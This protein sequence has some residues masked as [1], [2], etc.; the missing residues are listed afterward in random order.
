MG[1]DRD[2]SEGRVR[3]LAPSGTVLR[4][5]VDAEADACFREIRIQVT[6]R[7]GVGKT[8]VRSVLSAHHELRTTD[9]AIEETASIDV[10]RVPDPELDGDV[11]VYV[12]AGDAQAVDIDAARGARGV[13]VPVL[14]KADAVDRLQDV[15]DGVSSK[16][17]CTVHPL[18]GTIAISVMSSRPPTFE[19]LRE[20]AAAVTPEMLLT[21]ERFLRAGIPMSKQSRAEL[22][23]SVE[24][25]GV[26]IAARALTESPGMDDATVR[27]LLAEKSGLDAVV[28]AVRRAVENVR[29]ARQGRLL[30]RLNQLAA[31]HQE[32][33]EIERYL[34]SDE[35]VFA[36]MRA[37]LHTLGESE[38]PNPT[39]A[40]VRSWRER[41][42]TALE[43]AAARAATAVGRGYL[44][45]LSR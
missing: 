33:M 5:E 26:G 21:P 9:A 30:V 35:A 10:P 29:A 18:M 41:R 27:L 20:S 24:V 2:I 17:G 36:G 44:R 37:A 3:A 42:D 43:P 32:S 31:R 22:V 15:V 1:G 13:V 7:A 6:G 16:L 8:T 12:V 19:P 23:R 40:T 4:R 25:A 45:M 38:H 39:L 14:A 28:K 34:A 11:V